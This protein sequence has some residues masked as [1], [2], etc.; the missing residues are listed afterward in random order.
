MQ[1]NLPFHRRLTFALNGLK[2]A[3]KGEASF[4]FQAAAGLGI[5]VFLAFHGASALW[6]AIMLLVIALVLSAELF[7][8]ALERLSD[9]LHP[10][11]HAAIKLAKDC[12]AG[13]VLVLSLASVGV[14]IAFLISSHGVKNG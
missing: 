2:T 11:R 1:K 10:E 5:V 9:H 14:F 4:R 13:A 3:L 8:T 6:W 12:A 7:N